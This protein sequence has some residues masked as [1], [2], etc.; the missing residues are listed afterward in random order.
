MRQLKDMIS[1]S[2]SLA[3]GL[4]ENGKAHQNYKLYLPMER[5]LSFLLTGNLYLSRGTS[6]NDTSDRILA[7]TNNIYSRCFSYSTRENIA[8]WMLYGG[9][10]GENGAM[11]NFYPSV[12]T[13]ILNITTISLGTFVN[14]IFKDCYTL[15]HNSCNFD[16]FLSDVIYE[17]ECKDDK[18]KLTL[19]D[20]HVTANSSILDHKDIVHKNIAWRYEQECRLIIRLPQRWEAK[21]REEGLHDIK[22]LLPA[23]SYRKMANNRL[24]R[25]P[26][27]CGRVENGL[28]SSLTGKVNWKL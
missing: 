1:N 27:Y 13:D 3:E 5:A 2:H 14:G 12:M 8:M 19:G 16:I 24:T 18:V 28:P 23:A 21:A 6:W 7:D 15:D 9:E 4:K 17:D 11:L 26:I 10:R 22:I 20:E 25:S